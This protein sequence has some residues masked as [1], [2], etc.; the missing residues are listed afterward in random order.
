MT[1]TDFVGNLFAALSAAINEEAKKPRRR[2]RSS[3]SAT[4]YEVLDAADEAC[5]EGCVKTPVPGSGY[6]VAPRD[7]KEACA[8]DYPGRPLWVLVPYASR[9]R[10]RVF[11]AGE[12]GKPEFSRLVS[13]AAAIGVLHKLVD[14]IR[15]HR[16]WTAPPPESCQCPFTAHPPCSWCEHQ[17]ACEQCDEIVHEDA[18]DE[19][20]ESKH[21]DPEGH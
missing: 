18:M 11:E 1:D 15:E 16:E 3:P 9:Q 14:G 17:A 6:L 10:V 7:P 2:R 5:R 8:F 20:V 19:H 21:A 13:N 4:R 12:R